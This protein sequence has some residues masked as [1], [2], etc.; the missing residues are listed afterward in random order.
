[1]DLRSY[2]ERQGVL[3]QAS[4][5]PTVYTAQE[6]AQCEHVPGRQ[7]IKPVVVKADGQFLMCAL[8]ANCRID[9][10][11][12]REEI[13]AKDVDLVDEPKLS[14]LFPQ[15]EL[16][17]EPPVGMM[18]DMPMVMDES[19]LN[20]ER[21]TFQAGSH[22]D[23]VTMTIDDFCRINDAARICRFSRPA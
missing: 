2:L 1:M 4:Q 22:R 17:A 11:K 6:L 18:F 5:H 19:V 10:D 14:E 7:V 12:L 3:Y 13:H 9:L 8:P 16:G 20:D 23:A 15:C 21:V